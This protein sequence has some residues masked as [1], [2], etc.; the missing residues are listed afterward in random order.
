MAG[1]KST[2]PLF[3]RLTSG[4]GGIGRRHTERH[5]RGRLEGAMVAAVAQHG[6]PETTV[7]E[8]VG[9]AGVSKSTFY[10][11]FASKEEC[12]LRTFETVVNEASARVAIAYRS[13]GN[14]EER[15]AAA[16][17][18]FAEIVCEEAD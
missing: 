5:Q 18:R 1:T 16:F 11:H 4:P 10:E 7:S 15:L 8:L 13:A 9:L 17:S 12:F 2:K 6:Y 14:L 3:P